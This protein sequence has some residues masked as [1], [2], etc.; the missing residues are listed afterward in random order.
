M[1]AHTAVAVLGI[2]PDTV[3][4]VLEDYNV[5]PISERLRAGLSLVEAFT[6]RPSEALGDVLARSRAAGLDDRAIEDAA[7]VAFQFN[8][9][10][11]LAD[12][13]DFELP[14]TGNVPVL[15]RWLDRSKRFVGRE[16]PSPSWQRTEDGHVRPVEVAR[17][18]ETLLGTPGESS[19]ELR[20]AV[21]AHAARLRGGARA[22]LPIPED[23]QPY[24]EKLAKYAYRITDEDIE[25]LRAAGY[26]KD[27]IFELTLA[28]AWGASVV[29]LETLFA[30]L[31]APRQRAA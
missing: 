20:K 12:A 6:E 18:H 23:L 3:A 15:A 2:A 16:R 9:V 19:L 30:E 4:A 26:T 10:N 24:V 29:A 11:R 14:K 8:F 7:N 31:T 22:N 17:M 21:E 5:A 13:F 27:A 25:S 1:E 28:G